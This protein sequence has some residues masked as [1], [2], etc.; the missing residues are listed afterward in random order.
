MMMMM[1]SC[2]YFV[3][4]GIEAGKHVVTGDAGGTVLHYDIGK[5][6]LLGRLEGPAGS[7]RG[8]VRHPDPSLP[9]V[10]IAGLDRM[11]RVYDLRRPRKEVYR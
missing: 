10:A 4:D 9:F 5:M 1:I 2:T 7:I 11:A 8:L 3:T 6:R